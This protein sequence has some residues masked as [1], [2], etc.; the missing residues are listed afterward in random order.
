MNPILA[1]RYDTAEPVRI[2]IAAGRIAAVTSCDAPAAET[3]RWPWVAPGLIDIQFNGYGGQEFSAP[4]ITPEKVAE[5][6][7]VLD[8]FGVTR[9]CPTLTTHSAEVLDRALRGGYGLRGV[10]GGRAAGCRHPSRRAVHFGGRR[11]ARAHPRQH[12][13]APDWDEFQRFQEAADGG[14]RILT[15]SPEYDGAAGFIAPR[16]AERRGCGDRTHGRQRR[17]APCGRRR[18]RG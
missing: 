14:I 9:Y 16:G 2:E 18:R 12:C 13:H 6:T 7:A 11:P 4:D 1:R 10:A 17:A 8:R 3:D 5:I 15:M